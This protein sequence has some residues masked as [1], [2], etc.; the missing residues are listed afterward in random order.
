MF[1]T[2]VSCSFL[3]MFIAYEWWW[4]L[5]TTLRGLNALK[6]V[7]KPSAGIINFQLVFRTIRHGY[8]MEDMDAKRFRFICQFKSHLPPP[9][10]AAHEFGLRSHKSIFC[11]SRSLVK[12]QWTPIDWLLINIQRSFSVLGCAWNFHYSGACVFA[13]T[14]RRQFHSSK[15]L[16]TFLIIRRFASI[17]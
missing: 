15:L 4:W 10:V 9:N 5:L 13:T 16:Q 11:S 17:V 1:L 8:R 7:L 2:H 12:T 3:L 14:M 6:R